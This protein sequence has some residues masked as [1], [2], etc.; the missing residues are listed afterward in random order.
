IN[1]VFEDHNATL[2]FISSG[3]GVNRY[4]REQD[5]FIRYRHDPADSHSLSGDD[6]HLMLEDHS[7]TLWFATASNGLNRYNREQ[8]NFT[9]YQH[10][11]TNGASLS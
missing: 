2:W 4:D 9:R 3:Q 11:A 5:R 10:D 1:L 7:G 8:D 6:V